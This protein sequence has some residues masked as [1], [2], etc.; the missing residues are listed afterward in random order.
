MMFYLNFFKDNPRKESLTSSKDSFTEFD[1]DVLNNGGGRYGDAQDIC[2]LNLG[3][4]AF[5]IGEN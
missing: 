5:V 1:S 3:S 4:I 2:F